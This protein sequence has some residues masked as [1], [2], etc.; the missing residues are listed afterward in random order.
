[1]N[2]LAQHIENLL[3]ENDCVIVPGFGGFVA[4]YTSAV[5]C[6]EEDSFLPPCRIIGFNPQLIINDGVLVQSY[7]SVYNI[8]FAEANKVIE[9]EVKEVMQILQEEGKFELPTIGEIS[10]SIDSFYSFKPYNNKLVSP[11]FYGLDS[12]QL[13]ELRNLRKN[14]HTDGVFSAK[15][16][17]S[18]HYEIRIK[19]TWLHGGVAAVIAM[20]MFFSFSTPL[21]NTYVAQE[22]Y[23]QLL[24]A[25][26]FKK[27]EKQSVL[28][29]VIGNNEVASPVIA[30]NAKPEKNIEKPAIEPSVSTHEMKEIIAEPVLP[31]A[32]SIATSTSDR[33]YHIIVAS[34]LNHEDAHQI[35]ENWRKKGYSQAEVISREG[36]IRVSILSYTD[37]AEGESQLTQL[38]QDDTFK[39]S[40]LLSIK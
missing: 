6:E 20:V 26:L 10:Y 32:N 16:K 17:S 31:S 9:K 39:D 35:V 27:I 36:R 1:M 38:R 2:T 14:T 8:N 21:K 7:M 4:H 33:K 19:R 30:S 13:T 34:V 5:W 22:N 23:A 37:R 12:F 29:A 25:D 18:N 11:A 40:W 15:K 24:P 28:T 3:L